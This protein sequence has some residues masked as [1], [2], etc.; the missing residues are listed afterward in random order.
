[1]TS[2]AHPFSHESTKAEERRRTWRY[3]T[4]R[5]VPVQ[6]TVVIDGQAHR[7]TVF[8]LSAGGAGLVTHHPLVV[9]AVVFLDLLSPSG[10]YACTRLARVRH[11]TRLAHG[12]RVGCQFSTP[13]TQDQVQSLVW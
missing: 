13:L 7:G 4:R 1:M 12:F 5:N 3:L 2:L 6:A 9:G 8:D 10:L 11:V